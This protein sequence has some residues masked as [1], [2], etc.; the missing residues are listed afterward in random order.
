M[1]TPNF[2]TLH[3][4]NPIASAT[5]YSKLF[6]KETIETHPT[7]ALFGFN[8]GLMLGL[9]SIHTVEPKST[10]KAGCTEVCFSV[11]TQDQV[12]EIYAQWVKLGVSIIQEPTQM[13]FGFCFTAKDPDGHWLRV[14][15]AHPA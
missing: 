3:V 4:D 7:F 10:G 9:W 15:V 8:S 1:L 2:I 13:D 12:N 14:F 6:K 11:E 5:F